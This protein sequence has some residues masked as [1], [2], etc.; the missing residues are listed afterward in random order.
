MFIY[1]I[2]SNEGELALLFPLSYHFPRVPSFH[3]SPL[4]LL[5]VTNKC[6]DEDLEYY[7]RACG[8]V[9]GV[10]PRLPA[11]SRQAKHVLEYV[12]TQL[13]EFKKLNQ[14]RQGSV[15]GA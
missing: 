3:L 2:R 15:L 13:A 10:G 1:Y 9:L 11:S 5:Q 6:R 8:E 7:I 4:L 14:V 12:F